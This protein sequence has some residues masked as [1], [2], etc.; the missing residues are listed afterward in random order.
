MLESLLMLI[1]RYARWWQIGLLAAT[2]AAGYW[3]LR[4]ELDD[5][6]ERWMPRRTQAAWQVF[7]KHFDVGDTVAVGLEFDRPVRDDDLPAIKKIRERLAAIP[8]MKQVYD[9]SLVAS[10]IEAVPLTTLMDPKNAERFS[11]YNDVLWSRPRPDHPGQTL[12]MVCELTYLPPERSDE[13]NVLRRQAVEDV[14][15]IV[16]EF[17]DNPTL[18]HVQFHVASGIVMMVELEHRARQVLRTFLPASVLVGLVCLLIGFRSWRA[19]VVAMLSGGVAIVLVLGGI[20]F[21]G[22]NL[23]LLTMATPTLTAIIAIAATVHFAAYT[24]DRGQLDPLD[25]NAR[26]SLVRWVGVP[27][28]GAALTTGVGFL[29]L[30]FN[31]LGP[32]RDMGVELLAGSI[33]AFL[34][35]FLISHALPITRA[36]GGRFL[37]PSLFVHFSGWVTRRPRTVSAVLASLIVGLVACAWPHPQPSPVGLRVDADPFSFFGP[38]HPITK[39]RDHLA[40]CRFGIYQLEVVL[41]PKDPGQPPVGARPGDAVYQANQQAAKAYSDAI[42]AHREELGVLRVVSTQEFQQRQQKFL[43]D[44]GGDLLQRVKDD[45]FMA[46][47]QKATHLAGHMDMFQ[48]TF[49]S[50]NHDKQGDGALRLTFLAR[51]QGP[52]GFG[53]LLRMAEEKLPRDRFE[54]HVTGAIATIVH[55]SQGLIEGILAGL[56]TSLLV[57]ALLCVVLFRSIRLALIAFLPNILPV[58]AVY[59]TMG[60]VGLP[61]TSGSAMVATVALGIALNDTVHFLLHYRKLTRDMEQPIPTAIRNT[62]EHIG[63]PIVLT[64]VVLVAGFSIFLLTDFL[65]LHHFGLLAAGAM[66]AA[67]VGDLVLLPNLL[68]VFDKIPQRTPL[69]SPHVA[70]KAVAASG[71]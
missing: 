26:R 2:V 38:Q 46:A 23:G 19:T 65:P 14:Y 54:C 12:L 42:L 69:P 70:A 34:C 29:M 67:L 53:P 35:V 59:G 41:I 28:L 44:L 36:Y 9:V 4:L 27:C 16:D 57:M 21:C 6:P 11:L 47:Y 68:L 40:D 39:A 52:K 63:R 7:D 32:V 13:L 33:L 48:H 56:I 43:A 1:D 62:F 37:Q 45:G 58:A 61:L 20:S 51:Q 10:E 66:L 50:W 25:P 71:D 22:G 64:S 5:S 3:L 31:E 60:V 24:A 55:L 17:R 49:Q 8:G 18:G 30:A 15:Q